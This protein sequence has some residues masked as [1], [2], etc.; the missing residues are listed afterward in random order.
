MTEPALQHL[1]QIFPQLPAAALQELLHAGRVTHHPAHVVLC[2]E[3]EVEHSFYVI[4]EGRVDVFKILE[5]Q[6]LLINQMAAG[7][8]FGDIALLLDQ[9]R[10]ATIITAEPTVVFELARAVFARLLETTPAIVVALSQFVVKRFLVQ[11][12]KQLMEI[13]RLKRRDVPPAKVFV[14]YARTDHAFATRMANNLLKQRIDVW[15]DTFRIEPGKSWARQIGEALDFCQVMVLVLT[16]TAV[17][18]EN[19]D[20]EWNYWL[21]RKKPLVAVL[22]QP[23]KVPY[24]LSKLQH[25][26]F[27][28]TDYDQALARVAATLNTLG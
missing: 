2:H 3:G 10:T 23:C 4:L 22:H 15:L 7:A 25:I 12:Q 14:S 13:A 28:E 11:E 9:P 27:H 8:H 26:N 17:A 5:G 18:S 20:D 16:P 6:R 24:R 1:A 19:V 21:D